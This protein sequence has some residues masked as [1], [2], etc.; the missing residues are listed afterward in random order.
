MSENQVA[1]LEQNIEIPCI[2]IPLVGQ[3][4]L[5]P[6]ITVAEMAPAQSVSVKENA[7]EWLYGMYRWRELEIPLLSYE[8]LNGASPTP[9]NMKGRVAVFN[10]SGPNQQKLP[11]IAIVAQ[12]IPRMARIGEADITEDSTREK[13]PADLMPVRVGMEEFC[14]PDIN[15]LETACINFGL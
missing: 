8:V 1:K 12:G 15:A 5:V 4:L 3:V 11:F 9:L 14:I 10:N 2:L 6:T 7:P 13:R